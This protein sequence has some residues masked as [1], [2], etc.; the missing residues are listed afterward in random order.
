MKRL[1][2]ILAVILFAIIF[3]R[4][5][6]AFADDPSP[7]AEILNPDGT[8]QWENLTDLGNTTEAADWMAITLPGGVVIQPDATYHRYQT[9]S[10]NVLVLP[11]PAT[12]FFMALNPQE[13]GLSGAESMLGNGAA[14]A[15]PAGW[16]FAQPGAT[17]SH[18]GAGLHQPA[19]VL[20]GG[21]RRGSEHLVG[22]QCQLYL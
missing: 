4:P 12:L 7:W 3:S 9:P 18:P 22:G 13:S 19:G 1:V 20:P 17:G 5:E 14:I 2:L 10:G 8:I 21:D 15:V 11:S 16:T 6:T